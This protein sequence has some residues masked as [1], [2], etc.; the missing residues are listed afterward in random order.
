MDIIRVHES[1]VGELIVCVDSEHSMSTIA[2]TD[3]GD[4]T[5]APDMS[6]DKGAVYIV[7]KPQPVE[8]K[9]AVSV[10][11]GSY[12]FTAKAASDAEKI[13]FSYNFILLPKRRISHKQEITRLRIL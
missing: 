12:W 6:F 4:S 1:G 5:I 3:P 9:L 8:W 7:P 10:S 13:D 2:L 11:T